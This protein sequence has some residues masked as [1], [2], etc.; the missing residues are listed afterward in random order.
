MD[1]R[2]RPVARERVLLSTGR[3][4]STTTRRAVVLYSQKKQDQ[5]RGCCRKGSQIGRPPLLA[6]IHL[7]VD[8]KTVVRHSWRKQRLILFVR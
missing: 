2:S 3:V 5:V 1:A 8:A 7:V 4:S 6:R